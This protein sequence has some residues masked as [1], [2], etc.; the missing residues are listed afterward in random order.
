MTLVEYRPCGT[1][2]FLVLNNPAKLN[3]L[4]PEM[5]TGIGAALD[6]F[7]ADAD[8]KVLIVRGEGRSFCAG[9]DVG[10]R[11]EYGATSGT[12][13]LERL[14]S[15]AG[16][17]L[18]FWDSPKPVIA[19]IHGYCLAGAVQFPLCCDLVTVAE[20]AV[21]GAPKLPMGAGWIGPMLAHRIGVQRAKLF[22]FQL[23]YE[24]TGREAY[25][26]GFAAH[27]APAERLAAET[28]ALAR[29]IAAMP[30]ELLRMEKLS[31]NSVAEAAGFRAATYNGTLWD[32]ISHSAPGVA[33]A[34]ELV[35]EH[36]MKGALARYTPR[37]PAMGDT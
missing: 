22:M 34:K 7:L 4:T 5:L 12:D 17:W 8:A 23:G 29:R 35:R 16:L 14:R 2:G 11:S 32:A 18:R 26:I 19:Q 27:I 21:I 33:E 13:D 25:D 37:D 6:S 36:G 1:L 30:P 15:M 31:I 10:R 3:A 24:L 28:E 20:D 9:I